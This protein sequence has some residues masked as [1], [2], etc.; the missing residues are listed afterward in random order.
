MTIMHD[1]A[2]ICVQDERTYSAHRIEEL[3]TSLDGKSFS[4]PDALAASIRN[5]GQAQPLSY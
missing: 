1:S 5:T 2:N 4:I 3:E